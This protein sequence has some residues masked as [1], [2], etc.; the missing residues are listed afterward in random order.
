MLLPA[1]AGTQMAISSS[2][3]QEMVATCYM[4]YMRWVFQKQE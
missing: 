3:Q 2:M 1:I 4:E